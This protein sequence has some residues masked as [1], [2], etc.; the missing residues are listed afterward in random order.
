MKTVTI[1]K[2]EYLQMRQSIRDLRNQVIL[3]R[4]ENFIRKLS[5]AYQLFCKKESPLQD[6]MRISLKRGAAK[7]IITYMAEDFDGC[8]EDKAIARRACIKQPR[9]IAL[10]LY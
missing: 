6:D 9:V 3:L 4:D 5:A 7:G 1:P 10:C 2:S 8:G